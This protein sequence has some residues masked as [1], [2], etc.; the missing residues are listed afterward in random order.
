[1]GR[2]GR[3]S[4][5]AKQTPKAKAL[6]ACCILG[7]AALSP[8][9]GRH[10][11]E[12]AFGSP[13]ISLGRPQPDQPASPRRCSTSALFDSRLRRWQPSRGKAALA[14]APK[15]AVEDLEAAKREL[16]ASL[17]EGMTGK[18]RV[19][20][21]QRVE[22]AVAALTAGY[23]PRGADEEQRMMQ[24][25]WRLLTTYAPGQAAADITSPESWRKYVFDK[26]PSPVQAAVFS[27]DLAQ[28]VYQLIDIEKEPGRWYNVVDASP[29]A[30]FCIQADLAL[31]APDISSALGL[32]FQWTGGFIAV[33]RL[34]WSSENF[35]KPFRFPYPVPFALL[36]DR[37]RGTFDTLYLDEDLRIAAGSKSGSIFV[38]S[39]EDKKLPLEEEYYKPS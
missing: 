13:P 15:E 3:N 16:L 29:Y 32:K 26:G 10:G 39:K 12:L 23:R 14:G 31:E 21:A 4:D 9:V 20:A 28:R 11:L 17:G 27:N 19:E 5:A 34:P 22:D 33:S 30:V 38:L 8:G 7:A 36:G 25:R 37:A 1:M 24:G 18:A 6:S 35:E 2:R